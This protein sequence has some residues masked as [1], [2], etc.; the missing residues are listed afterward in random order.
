MPIM[1]LASRSAVCSVLSTGCFKCPGSAG[2]TAI[3]PSCKPSV[4]S[5][6]YLASAPG[7]CEILTRTMS[8]SRTTCLCFVASSM[9][10]DEPFWISCRNSSNRLAWPLPK[11]SIVTLWSRNCSFTV[12]SV[13]SRL[14]M[15]DGGCLLAFANAP[16]RSA[17]LLA[18]HHSNVVLL[19]V[20]GSVHVNVFSPSFLAGFLPL[21]PLP[22]AACNRL[23]SSARRCW[24]PA[25]APTSL[26][27]GAKSVSILSMVIFVAGSKSV[28]NLCFRA[29]AHSL[30]LTSSRSRREW[31]N[32]WPSGGQRFGMIS[33]LNFTSSS[34]LK[35]NLPDTRPNMTTPTAQQSTLIP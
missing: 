7:L 12:S 6:R 11:P 4:T 16:T 9:S 34:P 14:V 10:R 13:T 35:G 21:S 23:T 28:R 19:S 27:S 33:F 18:L 15:S 22:S 8:T 29:S 3:W 30:R 1:S 31:I 32:S 24:I 25:F 20:T 17:A 5:T 2:P 26:M